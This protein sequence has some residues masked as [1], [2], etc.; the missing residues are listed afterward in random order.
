M[1]AFI[2][3]VRIVP[4]QKNLANRARLTW[5]GDERLWRYAIK[6]EIAVVPIR[7]KKDTL[8]RRSYF[9]ERVTW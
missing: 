2:L 8:G 6:G 4:V 5:L 9:S 1:D 7:L 3:L